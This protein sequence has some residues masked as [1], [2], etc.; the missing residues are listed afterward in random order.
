MVSTLWLFLS[1]ILALGQLMVAAQTDWLVHGPYHQGLYAVCYFADCSFR[2]NALSLVI[3]GSFFLGTVAMCISVVFAM[4]FAM[5]TNL[6]RPIEIAANIQLL[7]A[8]LT[9]FALLAVPFDM[10]SIYCTAH[11]LLRSADNCRIGWSY[12]IACIVGLVSMCCPVMA[13]LVA[14]HRKCYFV[15]THRLII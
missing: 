12:A 13:R 8:V 15:N 9:G 10:S 1:A 11:Q 6:S 2:F 4:P 3:L 7:A 14:D 5:F